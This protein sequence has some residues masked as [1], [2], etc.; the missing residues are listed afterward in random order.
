MRSV[1]ANELRQRIK[2]THTDIICSTPRFALALCAP[3][4]PMIVLK[5]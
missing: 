2:R 5:G 4:M 3:M 1:D